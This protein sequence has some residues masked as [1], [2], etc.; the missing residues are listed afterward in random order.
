MDLELLNIRKDKG[1]KMSQSDLISCGWTKKMIQDLLP[2]PEEKKNPVF[3]RASPMKL[4]N[5]EDIE[6]VMVTEAFKEAEII[7][8]KRKA[9]AVKAIEKRYNDLMQIIDDKI[10]EIHVR[11]LDDDTL[12]K[13]TLISKQN[14]FA[15]RYELY[16]GFEMPDESTMNRW[17]VNYIRHELTTY[18]YEL[19]T[20]AGKV[21]VH[22]GYIKYK[23]A[24]LYKIAELYP[25]YS[26]E[27]ERQM[28]GIKTYQRY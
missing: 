26:D 1:Q 9:S 13:N 15:D 2:E 14:H 5:V 3:R 4:W 20:I 22:D 19:Y 25:N 16:G 23:K 12:R 11:K 24:V 8:N 21:G 18:D 17:V 27:C 28:S 6:N 7:A 10:E